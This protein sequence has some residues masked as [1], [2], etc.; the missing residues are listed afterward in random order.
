[1]LH[2]FNGDDGDGGMVHPVHPAS[3]QGSHSADR[4]PDRTADG[5]EKKARAKA[6]KLVRVE[7]EGAAAMAG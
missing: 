7:A 4:K 5:C 3:R 2:V 1:M 6:A